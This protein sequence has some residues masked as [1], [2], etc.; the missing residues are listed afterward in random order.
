MLTWAARGMPDSD[1]AKVLGTSP[2]TVGKHLENAYAKLGVHSRA[3]A[4]GLRDVG[5]YGQGRRSP[6]DSSSA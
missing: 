1:V 2:S 3:E 5:P 6:T 4:L